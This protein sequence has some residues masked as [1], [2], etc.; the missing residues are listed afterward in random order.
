MYV[1]CCVVRVLQAAKLLEADDALINCRNGSG[2]TPLHIA[3]AKSRLKMIQLLL[4]YGADVTARTL[5]RYGGL[6][7]LHMAARYDATA[8]GQELVRCGAP[9]NGVSGTGSTPLIECAK[10]ASINFA[11]WLLT[12][13]GIDAS[14][15]DSSGFSAQYYAKKAN[16]KDIAKL[17]PAVKFDIWNQLKT[18]PMYTKNL[19]AVK[20]TMEKKEKI[21]QRKLE[22]LEKKKKKKPF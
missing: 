2:H 19:A 1:S 20:E 16:H 15:T 4:A 17:L 14:A 18:E 9:P 6:C 3:T 21:A 12:I 13:P 11:I 7:A 10:F 22:A 8:V 5:D